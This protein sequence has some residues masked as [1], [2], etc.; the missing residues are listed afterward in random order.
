VASGI[1]RRASQVLKARVARNAALTVTGT[2]TIVAFDSVVHDP[3]GLWNTPT[4]GLINTPIAGTWRWAVSLAFTPSA[5]TQGV[6]LQVR[7]A[8]N[9][10]GPGGA[11]EQYSVA[12]GTYMTLGV[13]GYGVFSAG[14]GLSAAVQTTTSTCSMATGSNWSTMS[15]EY[16]GPS[17]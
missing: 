5:A 10:L 16:E 15:M 4:A 17:P 14:D 8:A 3:Y 2:L 12:S 7:N 11:A 13:T 1:W 6:Q 9:G